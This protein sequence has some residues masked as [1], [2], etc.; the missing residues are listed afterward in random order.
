M[1]LSIGMFHFELST[2]AYNDFERQDSWKWVPVELLNVEPLHQ[3]TGKEVTKISLTGI[4]YPL[5]SPRGGNPVGIL[6]IRDIRKLADQK[7]PQIVILGD[8]TVLGKYVIISVVEKGEFLLKDGT[9]RKS[10]WTI[11]LSKYGV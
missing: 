11:E 4:M 10:I 6:P 8:G 7:R 9:P 5:F 3:Y 1:L 2:L